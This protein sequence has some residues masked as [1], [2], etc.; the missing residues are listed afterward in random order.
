MTTDLYL[1]DNYLNNHYIKLCNKV[2]IEYDLKS[3]NT[4]LC[5]EYKLLD[6]KTI[7]NIE[8]MKKKNRVVTIGKMMRKDKKFKDNLRSSFIDIR[9]RFFET[10]GIEAEDILAIKKDAI[11]TLREVDTKDFGEC[12]FVQKNKYSSY[13]YIKPY[14]IYYTPKNKL[15]GD[16]GR[17]DVKGI[18]DDMLIKHQDFMCDF[19]RKLFKIMENED[20]TSVYRYLKRFI[21]KYKTLNLAVGYY[22]EF[23]NMSNIRMEDDIVYDDEVFI[24]YEHK[25]AHINIDYNFFNILIPLLKILL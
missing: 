24:P 21:D 23:N 15:Y 17:V 20:I 13:I 3:A 8:D 5:K 2:I 14:E 11:F 7:S 4:S 18:S 1:R 10:N 16:G 25:Q 9:R 19:F 6:E 12:H 22:R